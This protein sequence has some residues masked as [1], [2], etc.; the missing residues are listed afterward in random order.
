MRYSRSPKKREYEKKLETLPV[1][2]SPGPELIPVFVEKIEVLHYLKRRKA[3]VQECK[4]VIN[5]DPQCSAAWEYLGE[6]YLNCFLI[7]EA[8][9]AFDR[10]LELDPENFRVLCD[11]AMILRKRGFYNEALNL[12]EK[13]LAINSTDPLTFLQKSQILYKLGRSEEAVKAIDHAIELDPDVAIFW[14]WKYMMQRKIGCNG[15]ASEAYVKALELAFTFKRVASIM[16][17]RLAVELR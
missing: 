3:M 4:R 14:R 12:V 1:I 7:R 2:T 9:E 16:S 8:D 13:S 11:K 17:H 10:C 6:S 5:I 15:E